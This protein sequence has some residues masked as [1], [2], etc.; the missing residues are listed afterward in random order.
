[1]QGNLQAI[2][3]TLSSNNRFEIPLYQRDY[4]WASERW[5]SL[6]SDVVGAATAAPQTPKHWMGIFLISDITPVFGPGEY[7]GSVYKVIDGQQRLVTMTIWL[8]AL[9]HEAQE[10]QGKDKARPKLAEVFV[11]ESD[12]VA[13]RIAMDGDWKNDA[14]FEYLAHPILRAYSYFRHVIWLGQEAIASEEPLKIKFPKYKNSEKSFEAQFD[15]FLLSKKGRVLP[16][17]AA[18]D[19]KGLNEATLLGLQI[20]ALIHDPE[21]DES[22]TI[23]F[24]T[25][26]GMRTELEPL[27]HVRNSLFV[28]LSEANGDALYTEHWQP[29][30]KMLRETKVKRLGAAKSFVYDYVIS[31]G[32]KSRQGSIKST[33]G[34]VHLAHITNPKNE[35]ELISY[36][37]NEV[38]PSMIAYP[39]VVSGASTVTLNGVP[40]TIS[41]AVLQRLATIRELTAGPATPLVLLYVTAFIRSIITEAVLLEALGCIE[42]YVARR[43][44]ADKDMSPLR[45]LFI[46]IC[47]AIDRD[48]TLVKLKKVLGS[49]SPV[50]DKEIREKAES[51]EYNDLTAKAQGALFRGIERQLSGIGSM[52]FSIGPDNAD[53]SIEHIYP[54]SGT[55]WQKDLASWSISDQE[56]K[57]LLQ[58]I[59]N[60]TVATIEHN[61]RV[62]NKTF[63]EKRAF[64]T[65]MGGAAPL[66]INEGWLSPSVT[67][68][69][70]AEIKARS[71]ALVG[72]ALLRWPNL[73]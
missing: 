17:G 48:L 12:K 30:E 43:I 26:N 58:T 36:L 55:K 73:A 25:L 35:I 14:Y 41:D 57:P 61:K 64:P 47:S 60:L 11:Q 9:A 66:S 5:Q 4:Q 69:T 24:D 37:K 53:Y 22:Q 45:A 27:D 65:V 19:V 44:L 52:W 39:I 34:A 46:E 10:Q 13:Y 31:Q 28:R 3:Q 2:R 71:K 8:A 38:V 7:D 32:E 20:Y 16:R 51:K 33:K 72:V 49:S 21:K 18:T 68:W 67:R 59:G 54:Q 1:M 23:I 42:S 6:I 62:G 50:T 70:P 63:A 40:I 56:M 15:E 29:A